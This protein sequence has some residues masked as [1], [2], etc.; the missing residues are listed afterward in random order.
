MATLLSTSTK[1]DTFSINPY[2]SNVP[3]E[4]VKNL[5]CVAMLPRIYISQTN[6]TGKDFSPCP[7]L[8]FIITDETNCVDR[9]L[10]GKSSNDDKKMGNTE[11]DLNS[12]GLVLLSNTNGVNFKVQSDLK[13][14]I[15]A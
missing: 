1:A 3:F 11:S 6:P 12:Y 5:T 7:T 8:L 15:M 14:K 4:T 13:E 10:D 9:S 2:L